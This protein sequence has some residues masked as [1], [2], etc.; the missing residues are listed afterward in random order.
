MKKIAL[1]FLFLSLLLSGL[2]LQAQTQ[3]E[4]Y[5]VGDTIVGR[6]PIYFYQWWSED[7]LAD[8]SHRLHSMCI[9]PYIHGEYL[10][11]NYTD[12][13]LKIIGIATSMVIK[14][15]GWYEDALYPT[16]RPE[17]MRLYEADGDIFTLLKEVEFDCFSPRRKM[18]VPVRCNVNEAWTL[19]SDRC[20]YWATPDSAKYI[21]IRE[22]Y[23][24]E[25]VTVYDSFYIG[26]TIENTYAISFNPFDEWY[27]SERTLPLRVPPVSYYWDTV[28]AKYCYSNLC[29]DYCEPTSF[30][31]KFRDIWWYTGPNDPHYGD[32]IEDRSVWKWEVT[33][34]FSIIFPIIAIDSSY[35]IPP[36]QC[37]SVENFHLGDR[38]NNNIIL[39][40]NSNAEHNSWQVS[41]GPAG[42]LPDAGT[43]IQ[44][45]I[46]VTNISNLDTCTDY[47]A[48]VRAVCNHDSIVFGDWSQPLYFSICDTNNVNDIDIPFALDAYVNII[49]N[50]AVDHAQVLSSFDMNA[51]DVVDSQGRYKLKQYIEGHTFSIDIHNWPSGV[52]FVVVHTAGGTFTKKLL[53]H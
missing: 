23:F 8:T 1:A 31:H 3:S 38:G 24:D 14:R 48:Y 44:C 17:Y 4:Y 28:R 45:P 21:N 33:P 40:W 53:I 32:T 39:L 13:P 27:I 6:S 30:L 42:T 35:I 19:V 41:Y 22:Y 47:V 46:P 37:P 49:P 25:P 18:R 7:W 34:Y 51:I 29:N 50:P 10:Q 36:Y 52:Y 15:T 5:H 11:Y 16:E 9:E 43:I 2:P 26:Y 20:C 12:E